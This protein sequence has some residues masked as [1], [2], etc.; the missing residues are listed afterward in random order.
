LTAASE[1][2]ILRA[3]KKKANSPKTEIGW[4][5]LVDIPTLGLA[6]IHAKMDSGAATSSIHATRIKQLEIDDELWVEFSF[7]ASAHDPVKRVKAKVSDRR[8]V[9]SSNGKEQLRYVIDAQLCLGNLCW[10]G[11]LTLANRGSMAFPV[12][13]G[14]RA[15]RRGFLVNSGRKWMLGKPDQIQGQA[16]GK[17]V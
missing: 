15:L 16:Q 14:R 17:K 7:H 12:L 2:P 11:H 8:K 3:R 5:E 1:K 6:N 13:I 9:R 10:D 4:C